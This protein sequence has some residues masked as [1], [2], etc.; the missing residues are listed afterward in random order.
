LRTSRRAGRSA[1]VCLRTGAWA[2][3]GG[4]SMDAEVYAFRQGCLDELP[5]GRRSVATGYGAVGDGEPHHRDEKDMK[6]EGSRNRSGPRPDQALI[7]KRNGV[8]SAIRSREP[9]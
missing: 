3:A 6:N 2:G 5:N 1:M 9:L 8:R 7:E 4:G